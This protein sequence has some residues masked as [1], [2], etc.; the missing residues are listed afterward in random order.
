MI[1]ANLDIFKF[2]LAMMDSFSEYL[3]QKYSENNIDNPNHYKT[4][5]IQKIV[6]LF[7]TLEYLTKVGKDEVASRCV[8]RGILDSVAVYC[9]IYDKKDEN[10]IMFRHYLYIKDGFS[11]FK[12][13]C[14]DCVEDNESSEK[15]CDSNIK[16]IIGLINNH[17]YLKD[18]TKT[19]KDIIDKNNWK[20]KSLT[21]STK[22]KYEEI[23]GL[24]GFDD[25]TSKYYQRYL[26][27]FAHGLC[28]SNIPF[29]DSTQ[30]QK[31]LFESIPFA[32]KMVHTINETFPEDNLSSILLK[33]DGFMSILKNQDI[34]HDNLIEYTKALIIKDKKL[35]I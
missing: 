29:L 23:Y 1:K 13:S 6:R 32:D 9:F 8:L 21:D 27:Q 7:H 12:D 26:S 11:T 34:I 33:S 24:I 4:L 17:P 20:Y 28:L 14:L 10:E 15:L 5:I 16:I 2:Y 18:R 3:S 30:L 22:L 31:V 35:I 25:K 19:I